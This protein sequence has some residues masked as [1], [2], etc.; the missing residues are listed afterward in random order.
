MDS[1]F[2]FLFLK[3]ILSSCRLTGLDVHLTVNSQ[4]SL[5]QQFN[6]DPV[7]RSSDGA[8]SR[9]VSKGVFTRNRTETG[10]DLPEFVQ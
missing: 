2:Y 7:G 3:G 10:R 6:V 4:S 8:D 1:C 5:Q 9:G